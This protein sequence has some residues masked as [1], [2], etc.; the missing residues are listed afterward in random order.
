MKGQASILKLLNQLLKDQLSAI[1]QTFLHAR[2]CRHWGLENLNEYEYKRSIKAMKLS[3]AIIER[4][5]F[6]EGLPNL[7]D[8]GKLMIGED[9]DELLSGDMSLKT[10]MRQA[11]QQG[12]VLCENEQ[13]FI[14]RKLLLSLLQEAEEHIDWLETQQWQISS[15]GLENYLQAQL[16][17]D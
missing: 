5:L 14:S 13:D 15:M 6:L 16:E 10:D 12:I 9:V 8:L 1:N 17:E 11:L 7:Q 4:I 3:D 2:I